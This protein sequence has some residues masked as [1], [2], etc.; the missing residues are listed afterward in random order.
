MT[1]RRVDKHQLT[2]HALYKK[3]L[4]PKSRDINSLNFPRHELAAPRDLIVPGAVKNLP[5][6]HNDKTQRGR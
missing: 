6:E 2:Y 5:R 1:G 4:A 3:P